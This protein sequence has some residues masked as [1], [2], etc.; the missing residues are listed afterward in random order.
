LERTYLSKIL[1][2][3]RYGHLPQE[4]TKLI[5]TKG[6]VGKHLASEQQ[7]LKSGVQVVAQVV[8]VVVVTAFQAIQAHMLRRQLQLPQDV[9]YAGK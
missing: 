6:F 9:L 5:C 4:H 3:A 8:C 2:V 7:L 1:S